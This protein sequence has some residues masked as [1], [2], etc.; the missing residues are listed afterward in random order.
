[1]N[2][3]HPT[4]GKKTYNIE[5]FIQWVNDSRTAS[6]EWRADSWRDNEMYDG[7]QW[8]D[9]EKKKLEDKGVD[10]ITINRTFPVCNLIIG[11]QQVN[12]TDIVAK[13]RTHKDGQQS[14]TMSES[15]KFV[16]DQNHGVS[17][18][19]EAFKESVVGGFGCLQIG[20]NEDPRKEKVR[21]AHRPWGNVSWDPY[22]SP[23]FNTNTCRYV[24]QDKWMDM[25]DLIAMYPGQAKEI[26]GQFNELTESSDYSRAAWNDQYDPATQIENKKGELTSGDWVDFRRK[27]IRPV[28]M[29]YYRYTTSLFA[30]FADGR[31]IEMP[32]TMDNQTQMGIIQ[33][34]QEIVS[35]KVMKM[36]IVGFFGKVILMHE[37]SPHNHDEFPF[38]P[39]I[40]Y[41][42]RYGLPF[43]VPRQIRGQDLEVN[44]RRSMALALMNSRRIVQEEGASKDPQAT[45]EESNR[46]DGHVVLKNGQMGNFKIDEL[47]GLA[48]PQMQ[49]LQQSE[50][51]IQEVSGANNEMMGYQSNVTS[52]VGLQKKQQQGAKTTA[53]VLANRSRSI[54][55]MGELIQSGIQQHWTGPKV[56]RVTDSIT[57]A[58]RFVELN[59]PIQTPSGEVIYENNIT[60]GR[61]DIIVSEAPESDTVRE[62]NLNMIVEWVKRS[63]PEMIP[64]LMS[65]AM[66]LSDL[67]N[68]EMLMA[69]IKPMLGGTPGEED[70]TPEQVK[71]QVLE[72]MQAQQDEDARLKKIDDIGIQLD[73]EN[74]ALTN[75]S[76]EADIEKTLEDAESGK[77]KADAAKEKVQ[78][79]AFELGAT[80]KLKAQEL[81][82][83]QP[84]PMMANFGD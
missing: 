8:T 65:V 40:G 54:K 9:K 29:W 49:M 6:E 15:I 26:Q 84:S 63:P 81:Q 68:K 72:S 24:Y 35:A 66:E 21:I 20:V 59:K 77:K 5:K 28:E 48:A 43:G 50:M 62:R 51:E 38:V 41:L 79:D 42:D 16:V 4:D 2:T 52:G 14:Q 78:L 37:P 32:E 3:Q 56:L 27:R 30:T 17:V 34:A 83:K 82:Y 57:G 46:L 71:Q 19:G 31:V 53:S 75:A 80:T 7:D 74:K 11:S 58:E 36:H 44:K 13:G 12:N 55:R 23:W 73:L 61:Y 76:I 67:P 1:M 33:Q 25:D 39:F 22:G 64:H 60:Q 18:V 69:K 45:F 10:P 47:S 70:M